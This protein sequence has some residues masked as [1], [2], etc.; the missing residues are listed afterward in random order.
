M[1]QWTILSVD[2]PWLAIYV[3]VAKH[4]NKFLFSF[5]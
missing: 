4:I 1:D 2:G 3:H 5:V